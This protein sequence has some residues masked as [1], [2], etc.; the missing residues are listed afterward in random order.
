MPKNAFDTFNPQN[1]KA[2]DHG[3]VG[4]GQKAMIMA[5]FFFFFEFE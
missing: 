4:W 2:H 5:G 1:P 3:F